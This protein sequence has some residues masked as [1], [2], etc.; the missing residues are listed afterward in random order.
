MALKDITDS[1]KKFLDIVC[2]LDVLADHL[3]HKTAPDK[4]IYERLREY[5]RELGNSEAFFELVKKSRMSEEG[6][7]KENEVVFIYDGT[8]GRHKAIWCEGYRPMN[9]FSNSW[10]IEKENTWVRAGFE[11][12]K[13][14]PIEQEG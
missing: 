8:G 10:F 14:E 3:E 7:P 9:G 11:P 13:W 2:M 5:Y 1:E 6:Y 12:V 4:F